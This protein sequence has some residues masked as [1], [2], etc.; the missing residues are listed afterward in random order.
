MATCIDTEGLEH[1]L[2]GGGVQLVE[3][4]PASEYDQEHLP[5]ARCIPL[6]DLTR[7]AVAGLD[8]DRATVVYC[9][10]YQCDLS[11]RAARRLELLGFTDVYDYMVGKAAWLADG[12]PFEGTHGPST[13]IGSIA[14]NDVPLV[15]ARATL[16]DAAKAFDED[17]TEGIA[18]VVDDDRVVIGVLRREALG[19]APDTPVVDAAQP[20]PSTFRPSL[21]IEE[22]ADYFRRRDLARA[23][24]TT[25][26]G[27]WIGIVRRRDLVHDEHD[28]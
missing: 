22:M 12:L 20:G 5:G 15:H 24:V 1:M 13:R 16:A 25:V 14:R 11:P 18:V 21:P 8:P 17:N 23:L 3:V 10:D 4:L 26:E 2:D 28:G 7:E 6:V 9:F 27:R 19:L